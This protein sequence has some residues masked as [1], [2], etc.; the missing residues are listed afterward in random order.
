MDLYDVKSLRERVSYLENEL[1]SAKADKDFVW[2]LWKQL[3]GTHPDLTNSISIVVKRE[4][5]KTEL[6]DAKVLKILEFKDNKIDELLDAIVNKNLEINDLNEQIYELNH[7]INEKSNEIGHVR[8]TLRIFEEKASMVEKMLNGQD[9][10][11]K[12]TIQEY[13]HDKQKM[14]EKINELANELAISQEKINELKKLRKTNDEIE[15]ELNKFRRKYDKLLFENT[16][17]KGELSNLISEIKRSNVELRESQIKISEL[18]KQN[19]ANT[20]YTQQQQLLIDQ[21][22]SFQNELQAS[23]KVQEETMSKEVNA[24]QQMYTETL[25]KLEDKIH[26]NSILEKEVHERKLQIAKLSTDKNLKHEYSH[27][28]LQND[29]LKQQLMQKNTIIH[30]LNCKREAKKNDTS[31]KSSKLRSKSLENFGNLRSSSERESLL[32]KK[33][34]YFMNL[35]ESK[36]KELE[37]LEKTHSRRF[38]RLEKQLKSFEKEKQI[39][40]IEP[41]GTQ[42][43]LIIYKNDNKRLL[44]EKMDLE[45]QIDMAQLKIDRQNSIIQE[46]RIE[47]DCKLAELQNESEQKIM[48]KTN[49]VE[50]LK[51]ELDHL[52]CLNAN[53]DALNVKLEGNVREIKSEKDK[54]NEM[55][56]ALDEENKKL[57]KKL[58]Y[59]KNSEK[60][61]KSLLEN[62]KTFVGV[63]RFDS[64]D[65]SL[66]SNSPKVEFIKKNYKP[67]KG[68][69]CVKKVSKAIRDN[70]TSVISIM[71][72]L[73]RKMQS[74]KSELEVLHESDIKLKFVTKQHEILLTEH[75]ILEE[76]LKQLKINNES[77]TN[78][79]V[80]LKKRESET[81]DK[82]D[83][84]RKEEKEADEETKKLLNMRIKTLSQDLNKQLSQNKT[85]KNDLEKAN[86]KL[87]L[88]E[89]KLSHMERDNQ[90]KKELIEFYRKKIEENKVVVAQEQNDALQ[91]ELKLQIK[92]L[93]DV[94]EKSKVQIQSLK[95][96]LAIIQQEKSDYEKKHIENET[97]I[98]ELNNKIEQLKKQKKIAEFNLKESKTQLNDLSNFCHELEQTAENKLKNLTHASEQTLDVAQ[99]KLKESH[100][101]LND[102]EV[103]L[104][105]VFI[106]IISRYFESKKL[107]F[108]RELN[109][110]K[111]KFEIEKTS[112]RSSSPKRGNLKQALTLA[113]AV[114]NLTSSELEDIMS[115]SSMTK[116]KELDMT[117]QQRDFDEENEQEQKR[118][119]H[120]FE[121]SLLKLDSNKICKFFLER[122]ND[123]ISVEKQLIQ[124]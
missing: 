86:E 98:Q 64:L 93:T 53:F 68:F 12:K 116:D 14:I 37:T 29:I 78:E 99:T 21:L 90:Q 76:K 104:K 52:K 122:I 117:K 2:T 15:E 108:E 111:R 6:K 74:M 123:I 105:N 82:A 65:S 70:K 102:F 42:N 10:K 110:K 66:N 119:K 124:C 57:L 28:K 3:Q 24:L 48:E 8:S 43:Q 77:L 34:Q 91:E 109:Q 103:I 32:L 49:E 13:E 120:E 1:T 73:E 11:Y 84:A 94:N 33:C 45:E 51:N 5:E 27:L 87:K 113:S 92:K 115:N 95:N 107:N 112:G 59:L 44:K 54:M 16:E 58:N 38:E 61:F 75:R 69:L 47:L 18:S 17:L 39:V 85:I 71:K 118:L 81:N 97:C 67:K 31:K 63:K 50:K 36:S 100:K 79:V 26:E 30:E 106:K 83:K 4:K 62:M 35:C 7:V 56:Q 60:K 41:E 121:A 20:D 72:Q 114:L 89:E 9:D 46:I 19:L 23:F 88:S 22:K 40:T 96:R 101:K 25:K 80:S 55:C